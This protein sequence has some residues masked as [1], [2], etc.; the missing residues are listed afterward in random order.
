MSYLA[1]TL[2]LVDME[3][4]I[5]A[6][7]MSHTKPRCESDSVSENTQITLHRFIFASFSQPALYQIPNIED[8]PSPNAAQSFVKTP[9]DQRRLT[10]VDVW[11]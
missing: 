3:S 2:S 5:C 10:L 11:D 8:D 1:P 9:G 6:Y 4:G 7:C